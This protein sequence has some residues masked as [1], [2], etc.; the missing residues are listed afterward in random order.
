[1][2]TA[3]KLVAAILVAIVAFFAAQAVTAL[4]PEGMYFG[5]FAPIC[6]AIGGLVG[7]RVMGA[8]VG[9]GMQVAAGSGVATSFVIVFWCLFVFSAD[10]LV[11]KSMSGRY[12]G[13]FDAV[14]NG[15]GIAGGYAV[16]M[17]N[18]TVL[19][20]LV[21]GGLASGLAVEWVSRHWR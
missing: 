18:P 12:D 5:P 7:W 14:A 4:F 1:M 19:A 17:V 3:A 21:L 9:K 11:K 16:M 20:I 6:A 13:P 8:R 2:P 15:F 10:E